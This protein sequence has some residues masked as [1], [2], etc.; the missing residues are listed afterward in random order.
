MY[1]QVKEFV[2]QKQKTGEQTEL[3]CQILSKVTETE[4]SKIEASIPL[5]DVSH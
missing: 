5:M 2:E 4:T 3:L 1:F